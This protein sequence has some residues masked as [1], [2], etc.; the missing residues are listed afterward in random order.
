MTELGSDATTRRSVESV[1]RD[2]ASL[3]ALCEGALTMLRGARLDAPETLH[4]VMGRGIEGRAIFR[5]KGPAGYAGVP[6]PLPQLRFF[7]NLPQNRMASSIHPS[8]LVPVPS[9]KP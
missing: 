3:Y 9:P 6:R 8:A 1:N 7:V 2:V 4:H 5:R